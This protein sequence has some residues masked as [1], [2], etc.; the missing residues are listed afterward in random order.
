MDE[1]IM[2]FRVGVVVLA[3]ALIGGFLILLFNHFPSFTKNTYTVKVQFHDAPGVSAGTPVRRSGVAIGRVTAVLLQKKEDG[4][5]VLVTT[6]IDQGQS[7]YH[8]EVMQI[9]SVGLLGDAE[10]AVVD[11]RNRSLAG[12]EVAAGE[13]IPGTVAPSP[14]QAIADIQGDLSSA[15][16]SLKGAGDEVSRLAHDLDGII[17]GDHSQFTRLLNK[18]ESSLDILQKTLT[19]VNDIAGDEQVR[20]GLKDSLAGLPETFH[21]MQ[22]SMAMIQSTANL[23]NENL[24]NM[25]GFTKPLGERGESMV[26]NLDRSVRELDELLG[27]VGQFSKQLNS[28]QG[29]LGQLMHNPEL[30]EQLSE[31]ARNINE[32]S[33]SVR[34]VID[35]ARVF[36]E[37]IAQHPEVLG[38]RGA[39]KPSSGVNK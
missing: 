8:N 36:A 26:G 33:R 9:N 24:H 15:A 13:T 28:N 32:I 12:S 38:V 21:Q 16:K 1:R 3:V 10:L 6:E 35:N 30:Y 34:P 29:S 23:A 2:Q 22:K 25:E 37:K 11:S 18:T 5:G 39:I 4:K 17:G 7:I 20:K 14:F 31:A 27:Q 19:N